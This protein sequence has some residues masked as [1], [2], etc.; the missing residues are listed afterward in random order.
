MDSAG[1]EPFLDLAAPDGAGRQ[2]VLEETFAQ[3]QGLGED[4]G[5]KFRF[6]ARFGLL[7]GFPEV[8]VE[9]FHG[10]IPAAPMR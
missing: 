2:T 4:I 5:R 9:P 1:F 3:H 7:G 6:D 10:A 8:V